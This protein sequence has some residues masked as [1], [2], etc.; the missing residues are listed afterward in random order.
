MKWRFHVLIIAFLIGAFGIAGRVK[1]ASYTN[2]TAEPDYENT[3]TAI[4]CGE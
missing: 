1:Y 3:S 4:N 2:F